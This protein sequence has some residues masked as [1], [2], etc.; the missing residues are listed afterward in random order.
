MQDLSTITAPAPTDSQKPATY[1]KTTMFTAFPIGKSYLFFV[2]KESR[3]QVEKCWEQVFEDETP[4]WKFGRLGGFDKPLGETVSLNVYAC[5]KAHPH[6]EALAKAFAKYSTVLETT[7]IEATFF[8]TGVAV[9]ITRLHSKPED[10]ENLQKMLQDNQERENLRQIRLRI[11]DVCQKLYQEVM[12][13]S[14]GDQRQ[15]GVLHWSLYNFKEVDPTDWEPDVSFS[16]PLF[17]V[18]GNTYETRTEEILDQ[19]VTRR[20]RHIQSHEARISYEGSEVYVDWSAALVSDGEQHRTLIENNFI[21]GFAS[22]FALVL[23]NRHSSF[24]SFEAFAGMFSKRK[25]PTTEAVHRRNMA[26]KIVADATLP[27]RWTS[28]RRDLFLLETIHRNWSSERIWRDIDERMKLLDLHHNRLEDKRREQFHQKREEFN[29]KREQFSL[30][31]AILGVILTSFAFISAI[32]DVTNLTGNY[33]QFPPGLSVSK[34]G[35]YV[36]WFLL[37]LTVLTVV[38]LVIAWRKTTSSGKDGS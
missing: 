22:W 37:L 21:I 9:L 10:G 26:Y 35:L 32:A 8:T 36:S 34:V 2:E 15:R 6:I 14:E 4:V 28:K 29:H 18:D 23:M 5:E 20:R 13:K 7:D 33:D 11:I 19:V 38:V 1:C 27:I 30:K 25:E 3:K 24:F 12:L 17:F 16:Y 31:L